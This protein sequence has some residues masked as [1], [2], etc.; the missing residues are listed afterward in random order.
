MLAGYDGVGAFTRIRSTGATLD[1]TATVLKNAQYIITAA[2]AVTTGGQLDVQSSHVRFDLPNNE[3]ESIQGEAYFPHPTFVQSYVGYDIAL[4]RLQ[5]PSELPISDRFDIYRASDEVSRIGTKVGY[6]RSGVGSTGDTL[7]AGT[8]RMGQNRY[9]ATGE[10]LNGHVSPALALNQGIALAYDFDDG[11]AQHDAFAVTVGAQYA[12]LGTG[13]TQE[14]LAAPGD[15]GGPTFIDGKIAAVA[16]T[17]RRSTSPPDIDDEDSPN[18][19]FGEF[20]IDTRVSVFADWIDQITTPPKV[21]GVTVGSTG[22]QPDYAVPANGTGEQRK[23][24]PLFNAGVVNEIKIKFSEGVTVQQS[25]LTVRPVGGAP[26]AIQ[27]FTAPSAANNFTGRWV[28]AAGLGAGFFELELSNNIVDAEGNTLDGEW[29]NPT[30]ATQTSGASSW[31]SGD[32]TNGTYA[33]GAASTFKFQFVIQPGDVDRDNDV[34]LDDLNTVYN[35]YGQTS[36]NTRIAAWIF[37]NMDWSASDTTVDIDD[38]NAVRNNYGASWGGGGQMLMMSGG[39]P[40]MGEA[41]MRAALRDYYLAHVASDA[42]DPLS[43]LF[44]WDLLG[45]DDWWKATLDPGE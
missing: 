39:G 22:S 9:D 1:Y 29:I 20:I 43:D 4:V 26:R 12:N 31:P 5:S 13:P 7:A 44:Y 35:H 37:G 40:A 17:G 30:S 33:A 19:T 8:K 41:A 16:S 38:L 21:A 32:G 6:G 28:T 34:D 27:S 11:T 24:L 15:S 42:K 18:F 2:H 36:P 10:V 23:T 45:D 14:T 3:T 25:H